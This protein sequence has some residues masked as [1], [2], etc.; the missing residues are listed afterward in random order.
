MTEKWCMGVRQRGAGW[1]MGPLILPEQD[2]SAKWGIE[3]GFKPL[4]LKLMQHNF[5]SALACHAIR[6][7]LTVDRQ[8][9]RTQ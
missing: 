6:W 1:T 8:R 2:D 4:A 3:R 5:R 7:H 9:Q